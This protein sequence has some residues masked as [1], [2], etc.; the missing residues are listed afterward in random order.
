VDSG[1]KS[2]GEFERIDISSRGR[3]STTLSGPGDFVKPRR[4]SDPRRA[5]DE[6]TRRRTRELI[7]HRSSAHRVASTRF[8]AGRGCE[9]VRTREDEIGSQGREA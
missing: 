4:P 5:A 2:Q 1:E 3:E 9:V 7:Y 6:L 8:H